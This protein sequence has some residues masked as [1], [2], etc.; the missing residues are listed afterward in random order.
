MFWFY[1]N[2][3]SLLPELSQSGAIFRLTEWCREREKHL[4]LFPQWFYFDPRIWIQKRS[5]EREQLVSNDTFSEQLQYSQ[6]KKMTN[7]HEF[8]NVYLTSEGLTSPLSPLDT[9]CLH[10]GH[11]APGSPQPPHDV[12]SVTWQ[13]DAHPDRTRV[14]NCIWRSVLYLP[15]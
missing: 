9:R 1:P 3:N 11:K 14:I 7:F 4:L 13:S 8:G 2:H 5:Q 6:I 15:D 10:M 12:T